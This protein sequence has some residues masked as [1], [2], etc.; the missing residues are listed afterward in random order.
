M[1]GG[2]T[3]LCS[4]DAFFFKY[5]SWFHNT[6]ARRFVFICIYLYLFTTSV[7]IILCIINTISEHYYYYYHDDDVI[8][9]NEI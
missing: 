2:A 6:H 5:V 1:S 8:S 7:R 9:C 3:R 4:T